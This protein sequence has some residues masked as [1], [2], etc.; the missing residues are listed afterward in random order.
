M[1]LLILWLFLI[2][3]C[4]GC[5]QDRVEIKPVVQQYFESVVHEDLDGIT[6][7]FHEDAIVTV[8]SRKL[9]TS[10][11]IADFAVNEIFGGTYNICRA[12]ITEE[13]IRMLLQFTPEPMAVYNFII[14]GNKIKYADL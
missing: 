10:K 4:C 5:S 2:I 11:A 12:E 9:D 6:K 14:E 7:S 13:G 8:V 3:S 1:N